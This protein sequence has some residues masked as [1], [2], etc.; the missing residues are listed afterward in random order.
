MRLEIAVCDNLIHSRET[1]GETAEWKGRRLILIFLPFCLYKLMLDFCHL[2]VHVF[3]VCL[4]LPV[5]GPSLN[6]KEKG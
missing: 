6:A 4:F 3:S 1:E 5:K 2:N